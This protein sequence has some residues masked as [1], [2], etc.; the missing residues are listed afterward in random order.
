MTPAEA[1]QRVKRPIIE[2]VDGKGADGKPAKVPRI[3]KVS[4]D[5]DEVLSFRDYD[6][7]GMVVTTDGQ[8]LNSADA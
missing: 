7:H 5:A 8:K 3:K 6:T 1:A 4:V 2:M